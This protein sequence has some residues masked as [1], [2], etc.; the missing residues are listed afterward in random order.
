M[1]V[2]YWIGGLLDWWETRRVA[3]SESSR[4]ASAH[5]DRR[6]PQRLLRRVAT[7]EESMPSYWTAIAGVQPSLRDAGQSHARVFPW[8]EAARRQSDHRNA[9]PP[10]NPFIHQSNWGGYV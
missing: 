1:R 9:V 3:A 8:A 6:P 10:T 2:D 4:V 5:G 7:P